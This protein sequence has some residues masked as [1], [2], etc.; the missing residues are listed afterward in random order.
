VKGICLQSKVAM[1]LTPGCV[2]QRGLRAQFVTS[3]SDHLCG[4]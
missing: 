2:K 4:T 1:T 3:Q